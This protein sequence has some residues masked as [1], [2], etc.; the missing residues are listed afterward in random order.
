MDKLDSLSFVIPAH[1]EE[2]N[3]R[4]L[5]FE[6]VKV[7]PE[8]ACDFEIIIVDDYST[9]NTYKIVNSI[10]AEIENMKV[11][12]HKKNLGSG[13]AI[14]SGLSS[15]K[16]NYI[17]YTDADGQFD[18]SD[19]KRLIPY[20]NDFD[21][22]L[23][24]RLKR[25]DNFIRKVSGKLWNSI[26][27]IIFGIKI[28]DVNCAFKLFNRKVISSISVKSQGAFAN[29]EILT[30]AKKRG[31]RWA[32][33]GIPH[34]PRKYDKQSGGRPKVIFR[35]FYELLKFIIRFNH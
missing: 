9:D 24:Y 21:I 29:T 10:K 4:N 14:L 17:F 2:A 1:N 31:F 28:K 3:I 18:I 22:I 19:L 33:I 26:I 15:S 32:E 12:R 34:Y 5:I 20:V 16:Y 27:N 30:R 23:G 13:A 11:I 7:L 35:G 25:R 6:S 8:F